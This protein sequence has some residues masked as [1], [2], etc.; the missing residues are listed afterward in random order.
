MALGARGVLIRGAP[1]S[2]KSDLALRLIDGGARLVADDLVE[3][4]RPGGQVTA[5]WP[6]DAPAAL[7]GRI[8]VRGLGIVR[9]PRRMRARL[10][11]I[12]ELAPGEEQERLPGL[13]FAA[14]LGALLPLLVLDPFTVSAAAKVRLAVRTLPRSIIRPP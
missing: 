9:V 5:C 12:V 6:E 13:R 8:E 3:L 4:R 14:C 10:A 11:L 1:G 7:G 2:G